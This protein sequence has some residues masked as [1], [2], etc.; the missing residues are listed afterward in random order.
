MKFVSSGRNYLCVFN[1]TLDEGF[2]WRRNDGALKPIKY[3]RCSDSFDKLISIGCHEES[4]E[5]YK[6][7]MKVITKPKIEDTTG[8]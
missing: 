3:T 7:F 6:N 4:Q 1:G 5:Y 8:W 2:W